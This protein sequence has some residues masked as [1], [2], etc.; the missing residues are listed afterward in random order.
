MY[1]R[2]KIMS[3]TWSAIGAEPSGVGGNWIFDIAYCCVSNFFWRSF[4]SASLW[5][6]DIA[7]WNASSS[8]SSAWLFPFGFDAVVVVDDDGGC[9]L[10]VL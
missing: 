2:A 4:S 5:D 6:N 9:T 1:S 7:N 8:S 10:P 3:N